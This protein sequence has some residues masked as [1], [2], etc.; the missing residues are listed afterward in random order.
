[1]IYTPAAAPG[2][3]TGVTATA[4]G[5]TSANVTW[6]APA[7]GGT[8]TSYRI[9]PY[10]GEPGADAQDRRRLRHRHDR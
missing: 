2:A 9:T 3:V 5:R 10:V 1:M 8:V 6:S 4:G 7:S